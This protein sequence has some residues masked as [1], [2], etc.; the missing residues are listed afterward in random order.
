MNI[1]SISFHKKMSY[2][3][4][5]FTIFRSVGQYGESKDQKSSEGS[6]NPG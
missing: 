2:L 5:S 4:T 6:E 3:R 1:L